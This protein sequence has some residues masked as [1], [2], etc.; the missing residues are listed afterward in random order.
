MENQNQ[1]PKSR[2]VNV[3]S[4]E[5]WEFHVNQATAHRSPVSISWEFH[6]WIS[7]FLLS[8]IPFSCGVR[9]SCA[10]SRSWYTSQLLGA[11]R[12]WP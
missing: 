12:R 7:I 5:S 8:L 9:R 3:D 10:M 2:V 1:P 4:K 6:L 11:C